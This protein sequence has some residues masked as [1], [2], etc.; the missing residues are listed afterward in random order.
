MLSFVIRRLLVAIPTLLIIIAAA[1][2]MMRAAPGGP[3]DGERQLPKEIKQRVLAEYDLDKPPAEQ[4]IRYLGL[5]RLGWDIGLGGAFN[6]TEPP[7]KGLLQGS[8]GPSMKYKNKTVGDIIAE[9][10]PT[11]ALIGFLAITFAIGIGCC[12]GVWA[13][14]NQNK[15]I[16][17]GAMAFA[18]VGV[19]LPPLVI[20]PVAS[21]IFGVQLKW[22]PT[23]GLYR[24]EFSLLHVILPVITLA[25]PQI[26]VISRLM[27]ASMIEAM[28]SNAIRTARAKGLPEASVVW[29]HALPVAMIPIVSYLGPAI[30]T[31]LTG[32]FVIETVY[33]LPG[34]GRQFT[35]AALQ[36]DYTLVM[37][38]VILYA[39]MIIFFNMLADV[40]YGVLDPR[41]RKA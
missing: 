34:I 10:F 22:L 13:A 5:P 17:Y 16:D 37:G 35:V 28:R 3:F 26:A 9:G 6:M 19:C 8:L 21:L 39:S 40:L 14:L 27:R 23:G 30:S 41:A 29:R 24:D 4:F 12:L 36:R 38:V 11:S 25:L 33:Q 31:V 1:F 32:G 7:R 15:P 2:F 20:A 18:V